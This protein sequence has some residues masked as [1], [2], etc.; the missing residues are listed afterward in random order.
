MSEMAK[1]A[2]N[3][4]NNISATTSA[5]TGIVSDAVNKGRILINTTSDV[6][7]DTIKNTGNVMN[8]SIDIIGNQFTNIDKNVT[9]LSDFTNERIRNVDKNIN[10][11][12]NLTSESINKSTPHVGDTLA[13]TTQIVSSLTKTTLETI[14]SGATL[15]ESL[16]V[17]LIRPFEKI[18]EHIKNTKDSNDSI[19]NKIKILKIYIIKNFHEIKK[20]TIPDFDNQLRNMMKTVLESIQFYKEIGCSK[21]F[22]FNRYKCNDEIN[23]KIN[24]MI[25]LKNQMIFFFSTFNRDVANILN[26]FDA[27]LESIQ[28]EKSSDDEK[29]NELESKSQI[30]QTEIVSEAVNL[31][32]NTVEKYNQIL[33]SINAI[34]NAIMNDLQTN[35]QNNLNSNTPTANGGKKSTKLQRRISKKTKNKTKKSKRRYK[36]RM[37][38]KN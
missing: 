1:H 6:A 23:K 20:K 38:D 7:N 11:V 24:V 27:R 12:S 19:T 4:L 13:N 30:L 2:T 8:K 33:Q 17:V 26:R 21:G 16:I 25:S 9:A 29:L 36:S 34:I 22:I 10:A 32:N 35:I 31:F 18:S 14:K 37:V 28:L 15:V 3:T 5:A